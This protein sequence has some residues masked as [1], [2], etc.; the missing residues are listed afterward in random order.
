MNFFGDKGRLFLAGTTLAL[1]GL[2]RPAVAQTITEFPLPNTAVGPDGETRVLRFDEDSGQTRL[3]SVDNTGSVS[4][5]IPYGPYPDWTAGAAETGADALTRVL[6]TRADGSAALWLAGSQGNQA[7]FL[8]GPMSG[9]S[10]VDAAAG[11][12]G[13]SHLLWTRRDGGVALW[14]VDGSG[15]PLTKATYG[16]YPGWT[17]SAIS[18]GADGLTRLLWKKADGAAGL[19]ILSSEGIVATYRYGP[20]DR[21]DAI[22]LAVGGDNKTRILWSDPD[23][24]LAIGIVSGT[25]EIEYGPI[26]SSPGGLTARRIAAGPDGSARVLF[27]DHR[28][29]A[30]LWLLSPAGV[31]E[32]SIE[33][34]PPAFSGG[35]VAGTWTGTFASAD[36]VGCDVSDTPVRASFAL[37]EVL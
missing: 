2:A 1:A 34:S 12:A 31:F 6:W 18:D 36:F 20:A 19:S 17:A 29:A 10:A 13:T 7:S 23:G 14:S 15:Q 28:G 21:W 30:V 24:R 27:T 37:K 11:I 22:D 16:P 32:R 5:G 33:L 3:D 35:S 4:R 25:G 26:Y 8:F 9:W